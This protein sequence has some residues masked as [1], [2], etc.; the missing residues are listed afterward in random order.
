MTTKM[1]KPKHHPK[2]CPKCKSKNIIGHGL[3]VGYAYINLENMKV[4]ELGDD[5]E[6]C[7]ENENDMSYKCFDCEHEW[8]EN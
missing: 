8:G 1:N 5:F 7:N 4:D 6:V 2:Y 3:V